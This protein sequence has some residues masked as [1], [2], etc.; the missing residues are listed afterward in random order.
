MHP[1][2]GLS[3]LLP[4]Q[5]ARLRLFLAKSPMAPILQ[6]T[7][8][9]PGSISDSVFLFLSKFPSETEAEIQMP[10]RGGKY[11]NNYGDVL[12]FLMSK[13]GTIPVTTRPSPILCAQ[14]RQFLPAWLRS[15]SVLGER[16]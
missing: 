8:W 7:R 12:F 16:R 15:Q 11:L 5:P 13:T 9:P 14:G 6:G 4:P 10:G 3:P 1:L 2:C